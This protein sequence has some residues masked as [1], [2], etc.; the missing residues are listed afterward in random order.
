M[1]SKIQIRCEAAKLATQLSG[2]TIENFKQVAQ[3][4]S[5]FIQGDADLP[6]F[7]DNSELLKSMVSSLQPK[8]YGSCL[9][10]TDSHKVYENMEINK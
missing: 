8:N 10:S 2:T 9:S 3:E 1:D 7:V 6:E 5:D 4:I